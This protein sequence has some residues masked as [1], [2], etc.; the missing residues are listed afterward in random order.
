MLLW[1]GYPRK[2]AKFAHCLLYFVLEILVCCI[3]CTFGITPFYVLVYYIYHTFTV[4]RKR[5]SPKK[6]STKKQKMDNVL[7]AMPEMIRL[8]S[9]AAKDHSRAL[10]KWT[11]GMA[12]SFES[13]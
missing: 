11:K 7:E 12:D 10:K 3:V 9:E 2:L 6:K 8:A 5:S 4:N 13:D 1:Q